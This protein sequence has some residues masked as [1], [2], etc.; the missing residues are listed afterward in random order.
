V[1]DG[2]VGGLGLAG[3]IEEEGMVDSFPG[4]IV[5]PALA[6]M[7]I[8]EGDADDLVGIFFEE[9]KEAGVLFRLA[10]ENFGRATVA[11]R[12]YFRESVAF[13]SV[14]GPPARARDHIDIE[15]GDHNFHSDGFHGLQGFFEG[16]ERD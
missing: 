6:I 3:P 8:P 15:F 5:E 1:E 16:V 9:T 7:K 2:I 4:E 14:V 11:I 12:I 13:G 10:L